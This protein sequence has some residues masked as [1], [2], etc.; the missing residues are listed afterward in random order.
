MKASPY[1]FLSCPLTYSSVCLDQRY[2]FI[3]VNM[4]HNCLT[5]FEHRAFRFFTDMRA[6]VRMHEQTACN[7][8]RVCTHLQPSLTLSSQLLTFTQKHS[9]PSRHGNPATQPPTHTLLLTATLHA[10]QDEPLD[11]LPRLHS[12][13]PARS[14]HTNSLYLSL[15][16]MY[17]RTHARTHPRAHNCKSRIYG[18]HTPAPW[19]CSCSRRGMPAHPGSLRQC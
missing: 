14:R 4:I 17:A 2:T 19:R 16:L 18:R 5:C 6:A 15:S 10:W 1:L 11:A 8:P 9:I 3:S 7:I 12:P 13:S